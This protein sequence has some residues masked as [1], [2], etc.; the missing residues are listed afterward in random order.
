[1]WAMARTAAET[2]AASLYRD[3]AVYAAERERIFAKSWLLIA[4]ES[5][6]AATGAY[7]ATSVAGY[8]LIVVRG[9][10]RIRAFHNV[11][12]HRAGPLA[13]DGAG[14]CEGALVCKYHG[15]RY[16]FDGRLAS[17]RDFGPADNFDPRDFSLL[18]MACEIWRGFVFVNLDTS[19]APLEEAVAPLAAR[20][21]NFPVERFVARHLSTH[22]IRCNWK[23]YVENYLEGYHIPILHPALAAS[24]QADY[25]TEVEAPAIFY[26]ATPRDGAVIA[27]LWAWTW[28][29][30]A[31]NVYAD[32]V[33]ME[34]IWP[35]DHAR[36]RLDYLFL[37]AKDAS[38]ATVERQVSASLVTTGED[39]IIC[40][41]VQRN[42][43]AGVYR[44][45]RLSPKHEAGVVWFQGQI[46]Q[47]LE[48]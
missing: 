46:R 7:V 34:R 2:L 24:V 23:T 19:T 38:E 25:G 30:L 43:D 11:C 36:T 18:P 44:T 16:A 40:E 1:M 42:L 45:G 32:G 10:D 27:G 31:I 12:R 5:Q 4:H 6:L 3:P 26:R 17:A 14:I 21:K 33:L 37:F 22:D 48:A 39:L 8:P 13:Q 15:W 41:A 29:C 20:M 9:A 28:P 35:L 47:A